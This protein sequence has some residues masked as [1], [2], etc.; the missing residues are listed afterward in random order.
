MNKIISLS[1]AALALAASSASA[2][3]AL[4]QLGAQAGV[5][6]TPIAAGF[7]A[8]RSMYAG[9]P[10]LLSAA[11]RPAKD[12]LA[13]CS[14]LSAR[15]IMPWNLPSAVVMTQT[16]LNH[17]YAADGDYQ[18]RAES[19]RFGVRSCPDGAVS[20]RAIVE[21]QGIKLV[22]AGAVLDGN[23]VLQDLDAT[24]KLRGNKLFGFDVIVENQSQIVH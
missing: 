7:K 2:Q 19:A 12:V 4:Q 16:C 10:E 22:V 14:A 8:V 1:I 17:A 23:S 18:V 21:V 5:D 6:A 15:A 24:L 11:S 13:G 3:T 9:A 20:C